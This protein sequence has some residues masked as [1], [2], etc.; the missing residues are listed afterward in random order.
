MILPM[1]LVLALSPAIARISVD[2]ARRDELRQ[3]YATALR[4]M[5]LLALP[6]C[7]AASVYAPELTS[8][9]F[10]VE[11]L[12]SSVV[13]GVLCWGIL[14]FSLNALVNTVLTAMGKQG[15]VAWAHVAALVVSAGA[16]LALAL[17]Y[18]HDGAGVAFLIGVTV[19]YLINHY[20]LAVHVPGLPLWSRLWRPALASGL[21][22]AALIPLKSHVAIPWVAL[23]GLGIYGGLVV[24]LK[25]VTV[26][27]L[28]GLARVFRKK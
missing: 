10:G 2:P 18:G 15:V 23:L 16:G 19:L 21:L 1:S 27:E 5:F 11:F 22:A 25:A 12:P 13:F 20:V 26:Q 17:P 4:W 24:V 14:P 7:V 6:V 8:L 3:H 28:R 9:V